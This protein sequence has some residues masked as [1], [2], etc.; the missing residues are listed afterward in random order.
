LLVEDNPGDTLLLQ[1]A[2]REKEALPCQLEIAESL[3]GALDRLSK[4]DLDLVL[5]DLFLPDSAGLSTLNSILEV[6]PHV[7]VI[8]LTGLNDKETAMRSLLE[9]AED[10]LLKDGLDGALLR[11]SISYAIERHR[12]LKRAQENE[13]RY[14]LAAMGSHDGL[15]DW[16]LKSGRVYFSP[17][18]KL[19]LGYEE[20]EIGPNAEE[21]LGRVHPQEMERVRKELS[22]HLEGK[23][24]HFASEHRLRH[25]NGNYRWVLC[26]GL[27]VTDRGGKATRIAGSLTD[28]TH[29]RNMEQ[30]L[31]LRAFYDP[32]T[33]LPNRALCMESLTRAFA[34]LKRRPSNLFALFFL[35]LDRLKFVND[36]MGHQAGDQLLIEFARRVRS[37]VRPKDLVARMGGDEFTVLLEDL[38]S[39][40]EAVDVA[41]RIL[42]SLRVP[43]QIDEKEAATTVSIGIAYSDCGKTGPDGLLQAA[44]AAMYQAKVA[45]KA[46]YE[47]FGKTA[48]GLNEISKAKN[49]HIP[50]N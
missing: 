47:I 31:A 38:Q 34:R 24:P 21:W 12:L 29:H 3:R 15:W 8:V 18:W 16:D 14:F 7:P 1:E 27:A 17:R 36:S 33:G 48:P 32:L 44:D 22:A 19:M 13:E 30:Q 26:R 49:D 23:T 20:K 39:H 45:G 40:S 50:R 2:L 46:R 9:G 6:A 35:D 37:C 5:L 10:F 42:E 28:I 4:G 43:F 41:G 25:K 11:H